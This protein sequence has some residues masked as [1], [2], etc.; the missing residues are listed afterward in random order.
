MYKVIFII[1]PS[2]SNNEWLDKK[3][4]Q[5]TKSF[6]SIL[7]VKNIFPVKIL[8][9][10][11]EIN[12]YL[13]QAEFLVILTAGAVII[14][15]D[16]LRDKILNDIPKSVGL[17]AHLC[18]WQHAPHLDEQFFIIRT[19]AFK[20]LNF[21]IGD[22]IKT[23]IIRSN[24]VE[25]HENAPSWFKLG[26]GAKEYISKFGTHVINDCLLNGYEVVN[27]D[28]TWRVP[29]KKN[30][31]LNI[32]KYEFPSHGYLYPKDNTDLFAKACKNF[33]KVS[34]LNIS[35]EMYIDTVNHILEFNILNAF[36][37]ETN[38]PLR[39]ANIVICPATGFLPEI[40][41][42]K[43]NAKNIV[44]YDINHN[45]INF[46]KHLYLNWN[47][48]D[49]KS[50]ALNY[51]K[52]H[53]LCIEPSF[54]SDMKF[55]DNRKEE[56]DQ[57]LTI[58]NIWKNDINIKFLNCDLITDIDLILENVDENSIIHTSS[59]LTFFPVTSMIHDQDEIDLVRDKI[60]KTNAQWFEIS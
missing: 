27:F 59:I 15:K 18:Q 35:Q 41:A 4:M 30:G 44:I 55:L 10:Y 38:N 58:W 6:V 32:E 54:E 37:T 7:N 21:T 31:Y 8:N 34:G 40:C 9:S 13:S 25:H 1:V 53:N 5:I 46:K 14:E 57:F 26:Y 36:H 20:E 56:T 12:D 60:Y 49:Y 52:E 50:F 28:Q 29:E 48:Q 22:T 24:S 45:N 42:F 2:Y 47:G 17:M 33:K 11:E 51:A 16:L 19:E 43:S 3:M 39:D 23:N